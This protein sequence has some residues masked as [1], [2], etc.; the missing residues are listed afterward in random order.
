D[1]PPVF[2]SQVYCA[3]A[4]ECLA[5]VGDPVYGSGGIYESGD[6]GETWKRTVDSDTLGG[7]MEHIACAENETCYG[8][9]EQQVFARAGAGANWQL[10]QANVFPPPPPA[11]YL[12][13]LACPSAELCLAVGAN[14]TDNEGVILKLTNGGAQVERVSNLSPELQKSSFDAVTC[15]DPET[16]WV[17]GR[18]GVIAQTN[19]GGASWERLAWTAP[20]T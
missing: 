5:V 10:A 11:R 8:I 12:V 14:R 3:S 17:V 4:S 20:H 15:R 7:L 16:C 2:I 19:D 18:F 13:D 6:S 9:S 1:S